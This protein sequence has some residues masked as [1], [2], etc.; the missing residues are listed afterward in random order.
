MDQNDHSFERRAGLTIAIFAALLAI[1]DL[2]SGKFGDDEILGANERA[3]AYAWYQAKSTKQTLVA[4]QLELAGIIPEQPTFGLSTAALEPNTARMDQMRK[5]EEE[6]ERYRREKEEILEGS[7]AVGPAGWSLEDDQG[8]R[9]HI[10]GANQ[11]KGRLERLTAAG[12]RFDLGSLFLQLA[13]VLGAVAIVAVEVRLKSRY[14]W[15]MVLGGLVG[16]GFSGW[17]LFIALGG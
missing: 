13:L 14:F 8:R 12:D 3:N 1:T 4:H 15:A 11:W 17:G 6:V 2:L 10:I 5:W 7:A 16:V 9:G